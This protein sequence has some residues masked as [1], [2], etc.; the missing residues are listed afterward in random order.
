MKGLKLPLALGGVLAVMVGIA[1]WDDHRTEADKAKKDQ[2][3]RVLPFKTEDVVS[4]E[5][6]NSQANPQSFALSK[7]NGLWKVTAPFAY[8][9]DSE[10]VD[11]LVKIL[12]DAKFERSFDANGKAVANFGL[13][14]PQ[15][16]YKAKDKGGKTYEFDIG[17]K[18]PTGYSSFAQ[19]EDKAHVL[20]INQYIVTAANKTLSDFRD[21]SVGVPPAKDMQAVDIT[22]AGRPTLSL[23]AQGKDWQVTAPTA[24]KADP[25]ETA[26]LLNGWER[27]RVLEFL[28]SPG[29]ALRKALT[30][31]GKG[32]REYVKAHFQTAKGGFDLRL[33]EN[34]GKLYT[35]LPGA[36]SF[37]EIDK[38][39]I[40]ELARTPN[41][42]QD[43][44]M[45]A[46]TSA[47]VDSVTIDAA[48]YQRRGD[49][50]Y[51][52]AS[53]KPTPFIQGILVSL[54]FAKA[55]KLITPAQGEG[56]THAPAAHTVVIKKGDAVLT[57][58][59]LWTPTGEGGSYVVKNG[60]R[61]FLVGPELLDILQPKADANPTLGGAPKAEK[62]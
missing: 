10:G 48:A 40:D 61:Y 37:A 9:A 20:V 35:K 56:L 51:N 44:T 1:Y 41:D 16:V 27:V 15:L 26:K 52:V 12:A 6:V 22:F 42:L 4:L 38:K 31:T 62:T 50:W 5:V 11:R 54:E 43:K 32:T 49:D 58:F 34:N 23:K 36:D 3:N 29:P 45:F 7:E 60:E 21:R 18:A 46:Y 47:D 28:D 33:L 14:R 59:S 17:A 57:Q 53:N 19:T 24:L 55:E 13:D 8:A 39:Q 30:E 2:E 25:T